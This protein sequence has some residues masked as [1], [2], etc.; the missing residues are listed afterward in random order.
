V[1]QETTK[2]PLAELGVFTGAKDE[3]MP[4]LINYLGG[5][6]YEPF[7]A[8]ISAFADDVKVLLQLAENIADVALAQVRIPLL[9]FARD[10]VRKEEGIDIGLAPLDADL[11]TE[12]LVYDSAN[13]VLDGYGRRWAGWR[14]C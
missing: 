5:H 11:A 7:V 1:V 8:V 12:V 13:E 4:G 10:S 14:L 9:E 6:G 2:G 3:F